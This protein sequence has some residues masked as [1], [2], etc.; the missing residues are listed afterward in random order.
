MTQTW[1]SWECPRYPASPPHLIPQ[2]LPLMGEIAG[3]IFCHHGGPLLSED[4]D[5][6]QSLHLLLLGLDFR[7]SASMAIIDGRCLSLYHIDGDPAWGQA[8]TWG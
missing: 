5:H 6:G 2:L 3:L 4:C 1:R 7:R 8:S